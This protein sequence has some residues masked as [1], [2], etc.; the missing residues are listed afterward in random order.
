M[1]IND[2]SETHVAP[3]SSQKISPTS[4]VFISHASAD[5]DLADAV[6][7]LLRLGTGL[8]EERILCTSLEGMGIPEGTPNY[9]EYLREQISDAGLVLPL[10]TPAF[11]DSEVCLIEIGAMWGLKQE[12]F[13]LVVPPVTYARV[14][15]LL[16][17]LQS[18][19]IDE[20]EGL[21][22][23]HDRIVRVFELNA[24]T[25]MWIKK[26]NQ[27]ERKLPGLLDDLAEGTRIA[28]AD[29]KAAEN[30]AAKHQA[31]IR[32]LEQ[33]ISDLRN[34]LEE[35]KAAK[36]REMFKEATRPRGAESEQFDACVAEAKEAL[37]PLPRAV[38]EALYEGLGRGEMYVPDR[39]SSLQDDAEAAVRDDLLEFDED[40]GGY[41]IN[42]EDPAIADAVSALE[43]L[44]YTEWGEGIK[45]SF[46]QTHMKRFAIDVRAAWVALG[47][48]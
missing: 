1:I 27:F 29:L 5:V 16:G 37:K 38:R 25:D 43:E 24:K 22:R 42:R 3:S 7:D 15:K 17:K 31:R 14:E 9:L 21:S 2:E 13:P 18:A 34:Q 32:D 19:R 47:L 6:A 40:S 45:S 11:F 35:V 28:A 23:L 8:S 4:R 10:F 41:E 44:F 36:T 39:W 12:T 33:E 20:K 26:K 48:L 30:Q 46:Q